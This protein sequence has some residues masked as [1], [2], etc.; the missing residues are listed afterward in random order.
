M[1]RGFTVGE[2]NE[3]PRRFASHRHQAVRQFGVERNAAAVAWTADL[4][5]VAVPRYVSL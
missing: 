5:N 4:F 1:L 3:G 2:G